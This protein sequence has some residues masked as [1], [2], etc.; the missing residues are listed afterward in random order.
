MWRSRVNTGTKP[1]FPPCE[2]AHGIG[3]MHEKMWT[4]SGC[5][6]KKVQ[7]G[8]TSW[9]LM[10]WMSWMDFLEN[11]YHKGLKSVIICVQKQCMVS[12]ELPYWPKEP[13][14]MEDPWGSPLPWNSPKIQA[15]KHTYPEN[16]QYNYQIQ[17]AGE[18]GKS[19]CANPAKKHSLLHKLHPIF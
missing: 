19:Q 16:F 14:N 12:S 11:R 13:K 18:T 15:W 3:R 4:S 10:F 2:V 5:K 17:K 1:P 6:T 7:G 8:H 9:G